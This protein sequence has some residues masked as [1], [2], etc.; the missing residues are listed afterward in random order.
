MDI[1]IL[2]CVIFSLILVISNLVLI[3][4][5]LKAIWRLQKTKDEEFAKFQLKILEQDASISEGMSQF[6]KKLG[7][8]LESRDGVFAEGLKD[9][10]EQLDTLNAQSQRLLNQRTVLDDYVQLKR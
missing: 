6:I 8:D 7:E 4:F 9:V 10:F 1:A 5:L 3:G 2:L